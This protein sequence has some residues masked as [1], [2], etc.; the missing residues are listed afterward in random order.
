VLVGWGASRHGQLTVTSGS[1][2]TTQPKHPASTSTPQLID[3]PQ[4]MDIESIT[5]GFQHA[6]ALTTVGRL[7]GLGSNNKGQLNLSNLA[8]SETGKPLSIGST[9]NSSFILDESRRSFVACGSNNHGQLGGVV[10]SQ[11]LVT[12]S[13]P[14]RFVVDLWVCGSEHVLVLAR[15]AGHEQK[16]L[17]WGWNEHGNMGLGHTEDVGTP[18]SIPTPSISAPSTIEVDP[19]EVTG[20]WAACG[21]SWVALGR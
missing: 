1:T 6:L 17:G 3:L 18:T 9:W 10:D 20:I 16:L 19:P 5:G 2:D 21:T 15:N 12:V 14:E 7:L 8:S 11:S 13:L 4:D